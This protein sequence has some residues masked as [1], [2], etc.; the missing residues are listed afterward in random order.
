MEPSASARL[1]GIP[2]LASIVGSYLKK[3]DISL[4]MM[5]SRQMHEAMAP[6]F[7][8]SL[9]T[10]YD[11]SR[12]TNLQESPDGLKALARNIHYVKSWSSSLLFFVYYYHATTAYYDSSNTNSTTATTSSLITLPTETTPGTPQQF[13]SETLDLVQLVPLPAMTW[14]TKLELTLSMRLFELRCPYNLPNYNNPQTSAIRLCGLLQLLPQLRDLSLCT[15]SVRNS[16]SAQLITSTLLDMTNLKQ[17]RITLASK[18]HYPGIITLLFF[19]CPPSIERLDIGFAHPRELEIFD[20]SDM[21]TGGAEQDAERVFSRR[22]SPLINT[23]ELTLVRWTDITT[24]EEFLS[25]FRQCPG[26]EK[27]DIALS[28]VP[29]GVDGAD[30]GR[31]CPNLR[32]IVYLG[33]DDDSSGKE[34]WPLKI[35]EVLPE[36]QM[37]TLA[38]SWT[39]S[40]QLE[41]TVVRTTILRHSLSLRKIRITAQITSSAIR[42]ILETCGVLEAIHIFRSAINL[43]DAVASPWASS[44]ITRL[45]LSVAITMP[46]LSLPADIQYIPSYLKTPPTPLSQDEEH[47]FTQLEVFYRQIG[48]QTNMQTLRLDRPTINRPGARNLAGEKM[49]FPGLL[50]LKGNVAGR[51]GY[52]DLLGGLSQLKNV[53]KD[54]VPE[55]WDYKLAE[56]APEVDWILEHWPCLSLDVCSFFPY[57][58]VPYLH[59]MLCK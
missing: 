2:E 59:A 15:L 5:T 29:T 53:D 33:S 56:D 6:I 25:I 32:D 57:S 13:S 26:L 58:R 23:R 50:S 30:I 54:V 14:L 47:I 18:V 22:T 55:T 44:K 1:F 36:A 19:S 52:L 17:L 16:W 42:M 49:P 10:I 38:F 3:K 28:V 43:S 46:S 45:S 35:M 20:N 21:V 4:L 11:N 39:L 31:I 24:T 48:K 7:Y 40:R 27:L 12:G 41:R 37:E 51:P 9:I 8:K 34:M